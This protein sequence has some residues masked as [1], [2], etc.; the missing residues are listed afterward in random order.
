M[1]KIEISVMNGEKVVT[2]D[3]ALTVC[4][5][6]HKWMKSCTRLPGG[7]Y[8]DTEGHSCDRAWDVA[9]AIVGCKDELLCCAFADSDDEDERV[10]IIEEA[11]SVLK[12]FIEQV[13]S[14]IE[15]V[16]KELK[17]SSFIKMEYQEYFSEQV[18]ELHNVRYNA[19]G[20]TG[21]DWHLSLVTDKFFA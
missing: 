5:Y 21:Y 9:E 1:S 17:F 4:A 14:L 3:S 8:K 6:T 15:D 11:E 10:L 7:Y 20:K 19:T 16:N 18:S 2:L 13:E 12:H